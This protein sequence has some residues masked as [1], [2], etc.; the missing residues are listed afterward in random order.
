MTEKLITIATADNSTD[1]HMFKQKLELEWIECFIT[2]K[3][4]VSTNP[5]YS[6]PVGEIKVQIRESDVQRAFEII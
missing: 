4:I 3:H 5:F 2:E 1:A 6:I